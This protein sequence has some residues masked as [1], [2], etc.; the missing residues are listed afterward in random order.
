MDEQR[1]RMDTA[2]VSARLGKHPV[3]LDRY[4]RQGLLSPPHR[5]LG[6]KHWYADEVEEAERKVAAYR[7][8]RVSHERMAEIAKLGRAARAAKASNGS[9]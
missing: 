9:K 1:K 3:T 8:Q 7:P 4:V 6:R 5:I 2:A